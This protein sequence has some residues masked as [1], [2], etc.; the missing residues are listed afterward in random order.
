MTKADFG[1]FEGAF[2]NT[3]LNVPGY[4]LL[5]NLPDER[6]QVVIDRI[7][8]ALA[9]GNPQ[10]R[11]D[12]LFLDADWRPHLVGALALL[13]SEDLILDLAT[14][15]TA[16]DRGSWVTPQ[17]VVTAMFR[18]ITF[19]ENVRSRVAARCPV[20]E[21]GDL[22]RIQRHVATGPARTDERSAKMMA[23]LLAAARCVPSLARWEEQVTSRRRG[24]RVAR[25]RRSSG[26]LR[27]HH[28]GVDGSCQG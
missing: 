1:P 20:S 12:A 13:L 4:L 3:G 2:G 21:Q 10:P 15:W 25:A 6:A 5:L 22:T 18:D 19:A 28:A 8:M 9:T 14:C 7:A 11:V 26:P 17:L 24:P 16:I 27:G 23:S